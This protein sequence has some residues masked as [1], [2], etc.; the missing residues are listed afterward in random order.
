MR[1]QLL[2]LTA[3]LPPLLIAQSKPELDGTCIEEAIIWKAKLDGSW[4]PIEMNSF[5]TNEDLFRKEGNFYVPKEEVLVFG[6]PS[7]YVGMLGVDL[8]PGPNAILKGSPEEIVKQIEDRYDIKFTEEGGG[9]TCD[10]K[11]YTKLIGGEYANIEGSTIVIGAY[12]GP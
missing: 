3:I 7:L 10:L 11:E 2:W 4:T 9:Y 6:H 5:V 1:I 12:L 8:I